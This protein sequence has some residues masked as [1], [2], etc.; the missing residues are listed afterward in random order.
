[1]FGDEM[2]GGILNFELVNDPIIDCILSYE[3]Q[4]ADDW[5]D[6]LR[7]RKLLNSWWHFER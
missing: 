1:M 7:A 5:L 6:G 3:L 2:V 4:N